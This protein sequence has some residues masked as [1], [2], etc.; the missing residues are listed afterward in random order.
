MIHVRYPVI[1]NDAEKLCPRN[2]TTTSDVEEMSVQVQG[3]ADWMSLCFQFDLL[4]ILWQSFPLQSILRDAISRPIRVLCP[5]HVGPGSCALMMYLPWYEIITCK[6][7]INFPVLWRCASHALRSFI[8]ICLMSG[9]RST[10]AALCEWWNNAVTCCRER[11]VCVR[12]CPT[13]LLN[14]TDCFI[15]NFVQTSCHW[16]PA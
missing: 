8:F 11:A 7:K 13:A 5:C 15:L 4:L 1:T 2:I 16:G 9:D 10:C 3:V 6:W 12:V 14:V